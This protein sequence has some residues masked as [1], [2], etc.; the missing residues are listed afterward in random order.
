MTEAQAKAEVFFVAFRSLTRQEQEAVLKFILQDRRIHHILE[1]LSDQL[2]IE[3]ERDKPSR[4][5]REYVEERERREQA[6]VKRI[7]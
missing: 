7:Q 3:E 1:D 5:L 2:V 4:P 6:K